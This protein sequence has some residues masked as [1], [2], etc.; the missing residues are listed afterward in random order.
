MSTVAI[1]GSV[2]AAIV[3]ILLCT[4]SAIIVV[5]MKRRKHQAEEKNRYTPKLP[6]HYSI[7]IYFCTHKPKNG[8]SKFRYAF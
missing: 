5:N 2:V 1:A 3:V 6:E 8:L 7:L 4:G